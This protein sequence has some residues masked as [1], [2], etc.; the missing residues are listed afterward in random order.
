M[1]ISRINLHS[2]LFILVQ[3]SEN[4]AVV[5]KA[6]TFHSV[7]ISTLIGVGT[8]LYASQ[9]TFHSVYIST[10]AFMKCG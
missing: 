5:G 9:S 8:T 3:A 6:S 7:Y 1:E 10:L 4:F 2:T